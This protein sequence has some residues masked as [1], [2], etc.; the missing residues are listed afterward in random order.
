MDER[1]PREQ[2]VRASPARGVGGARRRK[3][4]RKR[5]FRRGWCEGEEEEEVVVVMEEEEKEEEEEED[6]GGVGGGEARAPRDDDERR[7]RARRRQAAQ[8]KPAHAHARGG[9]IGG[10]PGT[11]LGFGPEAVVP[12]HGRSLNAALSAPSWPCHA[13]KWH[14]SEPR[15]GD[16]VT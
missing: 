1:E 3:T 5:A 7:E 11:D 2:R 4:K 10:V 9:R 13:R 14:A 8:N 6:G 16:G 12:W 15:C